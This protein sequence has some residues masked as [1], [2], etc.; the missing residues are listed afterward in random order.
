M[1]INKMKKGSSIKYD[2]INYKLKNPAF[3]GV[4]FTEYS[5]R[6]L[7]WPEAVKFAANQ[8]DG[9][10]LQSVREAGAFRIEA[11]GAYD[12]KVH[13]A[14]RSA[15]LYFK[16]GDKFY[17]AIDDIADSEQN[18]IIARAQKGFKSKSDSYNGTHLLPVNDSLVKGA[19]SR[20]EKTGRI[21]EA[22]ENNILELRT[23]TFDGKS[24][25]GQN[26]WN[27]AI[28][29]DFAEPY[30]EMIHKRYT[31]SY[32]IWP[33]ILDI[34]RVWSLTPKTLE[35]I[36]VDGNFV[37]VGPV[38][39]VGV[40]NDIDGVTVGYYSGNVCGSGV[41]RSCGVRHAKNFS[42]ENG[43]RVVTLDEKIYAEIRKM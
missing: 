19:L 22:T 28:L 24:E 42:T 39:L 33:S 10:I 31:E 36:G 43:E 26:D 6:G 32:G 5:K 15:A 30:A 25:F 23:K 9:A 8:G 40:Y 2:G 27:R 4:E 21:V 14:T 1:K 18:I 11:D 37:D 13:P 7:D 41:G 34:G 35:K 12:A 16:M 20:A 17:C 29:L 38:S 3:K